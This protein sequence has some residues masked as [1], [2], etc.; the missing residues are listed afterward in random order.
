MPETFGAL[1]GL[2]GT[3]GDRGLSDRAFRLAFFG[4][5]DRGFNMVG[6]EFGRA[7]GDFED[8]VLVAKAGAFGGVRPDLFTFVASLRCGV[9]MTAAR[10]C[11][12]TFI[13]ATCSSS[14]AYGNG[15]GELARRWRGDAEVA[16]VLVDDRTVVAFV[17]AQLLRDA[18]RRW[19]RGG[20]GGAGGGCLANFADTTATTIRTAQRAR[21]IPT[22][23]LALILTTRYGS[24][25]VS[26][27]Q[28][29]ASY[30]EVGHW[31]TFNTPSS[32]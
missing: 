15:L 27:P 6:D 32:V 5:I 3:E 22:C 10:S 17:E 7:V 31:H 29:R 24:C 12:P 13:R 8:G 1:D 14:R 2:A 4:M 9:S 25:A 18:L 20:G 28:Y 21:P 30:G 26:L 19:W 11:G 16:R 23:W